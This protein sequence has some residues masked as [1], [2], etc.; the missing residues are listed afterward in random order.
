MGFSIGTET[1]AHPLM[2]HEF[3]THF[4]RREICERFAKG[5]RKAIQLVFP[6]SGNL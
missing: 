4:Y 3:E 1:P 6:L 5:W 2:K